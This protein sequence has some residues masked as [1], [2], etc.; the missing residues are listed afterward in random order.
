[1]EDTRVVFD[2]AKFIIFYNIKNVI[3]QT[4]VDTT[5]FENVEISNIFPCD[6]ISQTA[7]HSSIN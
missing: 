2:G 6:G 3:L 7:L 5:L 1:M 4:G